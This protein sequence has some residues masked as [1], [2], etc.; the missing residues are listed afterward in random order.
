MADFDPMQPVGGSPLPPAYEAP[1]SFTAWS[2]ITVSDKTVTQQPA[3]PIS[4]QEIAEQRN[5]VQELLRSAGFALKGMPGERR[6][7]EVA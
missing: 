5:A 6:E 1:L 3:S 2:P 4:A 7:G